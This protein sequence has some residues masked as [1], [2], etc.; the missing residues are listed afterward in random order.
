[1]NFQSDKWNTSEE[2]RFTINVAIDFITSEKESRKKCPLEWECQFRERIGI[3]MGI[4]D[5]W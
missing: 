5:K 3:L 4:G 1:L 2:G